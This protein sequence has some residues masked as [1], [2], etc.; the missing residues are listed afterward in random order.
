MLL[1]LVHGGKGVI[2][3]FSLITLGVA[4]STINTKIDSIYH[5]AGLALVIAMVTLIMTLAALV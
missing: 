3:L 2:L 1:L 4:A 5:L